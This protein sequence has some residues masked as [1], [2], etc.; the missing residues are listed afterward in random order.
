[1]TSDDSL[2][3][4]EVLFIN[5]RCR[6]DYEAMPADVRESA[7]QTIDALQNARPLPAKLYRPLHHTLTGIH[8]I[9]LPHDDNTYRVY[10]TL[11][12]P[13]VIMVLDEFC[14]EHETN[15]KADYDKRKLR[16]EQFAK[17]NC[18]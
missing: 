1:M 18:R 16:R 2:D 14:T 11:Q 13:W 15:L 9:R 7:D 6:V 10:V 4:R 17:E 12:F 5:E 8:E 3:V